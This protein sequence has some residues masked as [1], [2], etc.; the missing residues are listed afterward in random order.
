[1]QVPAVPEK[2]TPLILDEEGRTVDRSGKAV[3]LTQIAPTLKANIRAK[4]RQEFRAQLTEK[5]RSFRSES[6]RT[7]FQYKIVE[8]AYILLYLFVG[9]SHFCNMLGFC[10][11]FIQSC[12]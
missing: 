6:S 7:F 3:K 10:N 11:S 8:P 1:M 9:N 5:V 12:F 4:K 2:P